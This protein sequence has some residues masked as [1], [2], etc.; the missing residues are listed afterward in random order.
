MLREQRARSSAD[1][2]SEIDEHSTTSFGREPPAP[3][4]SPARAGD[5]F[6]TSSHVETMQNT[7]SQAA[8]SGRRSAIFAPCFASGSALRACDSRP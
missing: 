7:T 8:S 2:S 5:D 3:D 6:L 4:R 1:P